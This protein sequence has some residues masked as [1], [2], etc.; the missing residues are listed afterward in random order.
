MTSNLLR[1]AMLATALAGCTDDSL[2]DTRGDPRELTVNWAF[3]TL[4]GGTAPCPPGKEAFLF[5]HTNGNIG[6]FREAIPCES[7]GT[8]TMTLFTSGVQESE[9][10][11]G[12]RYLEGYT[13][14]YSVWLTVED[15]PDPFERLGSF[16]VYTDLRYGD[17]T[18]D[19][20]IYP[21]AGVGLI[22]WSLE[23]AND[24]AYDPI[25]CADAGIDTIEYRYH[26][27]S[28]PTAF[29]YTER[30]ACTEGSRPSADESDL[31][32]YGNGTGRTPFLAPGEYSAHTAAIRNGIDVVHGDVHTL[33]IEPRMYV[34]ER[35]DTLAIP[36]R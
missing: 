29:R 23:G 33:R 17:Q 27:V 3:K 12:E 20:E 32:L 8:F 25:T 31:E 16:R 15:S 5:A 1:F 26:A 2:L 7:T 22:Q 24:P 30:W 36:M 13:P 18:V 10:D 9:W 35:Y 11:S 28:D 14:Q 4:G 6:A 21:D 19:L 34:S